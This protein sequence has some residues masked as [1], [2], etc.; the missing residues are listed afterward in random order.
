[1]IVIITLSL[2]LTLITFPSSWL[3]RANMNH[4]VSEPRTRITTSTHTRSNVQQHHSSLHSSSTHSSHEDQPT[5]PPKDETDAEKA[6][7]LLAA[8]LLFYKESLTNPIADF[9]ASLSPFLFDLQTFTQQ[10]S[11][12]QQIILSGGTTQEQ[13]S[14]RATF[15]TAPWQGDS[16]NTTIIDFLFWTIANLRKPLV[17][18]KLSIEVCLRVSP[19]LYPFTHIL[20]LHRID[21]FSP[22]PTEL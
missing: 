22:L 10:H 14:A 8:T 13:Q 19:S 18:F 21:D 2:F 4:K 16:T 15:L 6:D 1:M 12:A 20:Q 7:R 5:N 17:P 9:N 11:L 3:T